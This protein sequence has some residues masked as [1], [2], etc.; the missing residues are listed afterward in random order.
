MTPLERAARALAKEEYPDQPQEWHDDCWRSW[1]GS[2]RAVIKAIRE[3]SEEQRVAGMA[4]PNYI[5]D[6]TS[7]RGAGNIYIAMIDAL[8][9]E[10]R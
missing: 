7:R 4:A 3:P 8:L 6:Q 1:E 5:E 2:A 9:E 10:E